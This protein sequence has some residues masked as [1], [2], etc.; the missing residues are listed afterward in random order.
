MSIK[1]KITISALGDISFTGNIDKNPSLDFFKK[2]SDTWSDSDLVVGNLEG[3][4]LDDGRSIPGKCVLKADPK[5]ADVLSETGINLVSLANNHM[6]DYGAKGLFKTID[7]L[8]KAGIHYLGAGENPEN[9]CRPLILDLNNVR[10]GFLARSSVIISSSTY[11][12][13]QDQPG[14]ASFDYSETI[15]QAKQLKH[16]TDLVILL[17]HWG[18]E[19]YHFPSSSQRALAKQL[20]KNGVDII[21]G[22]HPHVLQGMEYIGQGMVAYSLG[23]FIFDNFDWS[24]CDSNGNTIPQKYILSSE[25][26]RGMILKLK[27]EENKPV[28]NRIILTQINNNGT[29]IKI[30]DEKAYK[31]NRFLSKKMGSFYYKS[32]WRLY[33]LRQEWHLRIKNQFSFWNIIR[34][35]YKIRPSHIK[36][37]L[38]V[39][40]K[41]SQIASEK[42]TNP[43]D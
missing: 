35:I 29:I 12:A 34:K 27:W 9:A 11:Y 17:M 37:L 15:R 6:M 3:P 33:A 28:S 8:H 24:F 40:K 19:N 7:V 5:W 42:T 39:L 20:L 10:I 4:L 22:H 14:I 21:I 23:N 2:I 38:S 1:K 32:W 26:R 16:N 13:T 43:Y 31:T 30:D 36:R 41:S 25:N 18:I